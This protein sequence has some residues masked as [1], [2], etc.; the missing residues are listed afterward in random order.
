MEEKRDHLTVVIGA[1][2]IAEE[3]R[4]SLVQ[5]KVAHAGVSN[6][7]R[8]LR[9]SMVLGQ[10]DLV[11]VCIALDRSTL[12]R[13][14]R[15]LKTLLADNHCFPQAV[16]SV[17]LL[18]DIG[19]NRDAA[20]IGCDLYVDDSAN[21]V[22]AVKLLTRRWKRDQARRSLKSNRSRMFGPLSENP[23]SSMWSWGDKS[24]P[25]E[26]ASLVGEDSDRLHQDHS[27]A[28]PRRRSQPSRR[29]SST[30]RPS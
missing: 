7:L 2:G 29:R 27:P 19:L 14:G 1:S 9:K 17:G 21:A 25:A 28:R 8:G 26:L 18:T 13:H 22:S 15:S 6:H 5:H 24:L 10:N 4:R 16:R 11:V 30:T 23:Q 12:S 3:L 20:E